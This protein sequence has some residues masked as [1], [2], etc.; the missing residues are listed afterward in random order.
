MKYDMAIHFPYSELETLYQELEKLRRGEQQ[1]L[2]NNPKWQ[3]K[4]EISNY[5]NELIGDDST[6]Q[7]IIK[8]EGSKHPMNSNLVG[9]HL[10]GLIDIQADLKELC[11]SFN[12]Q[13]F[14][15]ILHEL[16]L[17]AYFDPSDYEND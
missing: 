5:I 2:D 9:G 14:K 4:S 16:D 3:F 12:M 1:M 15:E 7:R 8:N 17:I 11:K 13:T 10:D 6:L